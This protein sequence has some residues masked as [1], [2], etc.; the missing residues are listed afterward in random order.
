MEQGETRIETDTM[1]A[2]EVPRDAYF[3]AQTMRA[4]KNFPVGNHVMPPAFIHALGILKS[5]A[6][7]ANLAL[8]TLDP[9]R[10]EAIVQAGDEVA[11]GLYDDQF[12]VSVYQTGSG[13]SS[14]MNANEVIANRA[15]EILAG[16][17]GGRGR[18]HP[19]DHVNMGQ[20]SNDLIPTAIHLSAMLQIQG[21]LIPALSELETALRKKACEFWPIIKTGRTHL[22]D[23]TPI[24]LGQEFLGYADQVKL[25][26]DR[27]RREVDALGAVALGGTAVGT[28]INCD[29]NFARITLKRVADAT[30]LPIRETEHHFQAQSSIDGLVAVSGTLRVAAVGLTKIANDIRW[31]ASGPMAGLGEI[32]LPELQPGSSIM[33]GK[34][35]PVIAESLIMVA[36]QVIG[37]DATITVAGQAGNFELNVMLPVVAYDLLDGIDILAAASRN[38]SRNALA[39]LKATERGP[40]M[41]EKGLMLVT[42]LAPA[43]GYDTAATIAKEAYKTGRTVRELALERTDL[44]K[45]DLDR[46]L[47]PTSMVEPPG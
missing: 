7:A 28:G 36:A 9:Q 8:G 6:A 13:T 21:D 12:P 25:C 15:S 14:N 17:R 27:C 2:I 39:G 4:L 47:D 16:E 3:G 41:V 40:E 20:S 30:G 32:E 35:N 22:Q 37:Y 44:S 26:L 38:F 42:A 29:P 43:V 5:A 19:N 45:A 34:V 23:A 1:G 24:R 31:M 11:H 10:A 33:P 46:L 18:V